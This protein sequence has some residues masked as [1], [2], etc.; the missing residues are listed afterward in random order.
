LIAPPRD[1]PAGDTDIAFA[2]SAVEA[3][4]AIE[5]Y[6]SIADKDMLRAVVHAEKA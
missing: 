3:G 1:E 5:L 2:S 4:G 6:Y